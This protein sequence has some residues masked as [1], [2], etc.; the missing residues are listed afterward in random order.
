MPDHLD[1]QAAH[2]APHYRLPVC[3][4]FT[5]QVDFWEIVCYRADVEEGPFKLRHSDML[6][7]LSHPAFARA[8]REATHGRRAP[9]MPIAEE[10]EPCYV[11]RPQAEGWPG[12]TLSK[13]RAYVERGW[14]VHL[15]HHLHAKWVLNYL[16]LERQRR[17]DKAGS[18]SGTSPPS[19]DHFTLSWMKLKGALESAKGKKVEYRKLKDGLLLLERQGILTPLTGQQTASLG[20]ARR[21]QHRLNVHRL[22]DV[23]PA[24]LRPCQP[25]EGDPL[26]LDWAI[27]C[28]LRFLAGD[29]QQQGKARPW[30]LDWLHGEV[31][32]DLEMERQRRVAVRRELT[33]GAV[34]VLAQAGILWHE[35]AGYALS[36]QAAEELV[37]EDSQRMPFAAAGYALSPQAAEESHAL[38]DLKEQAMQDLARA[39]GNLEG[40]PTPSTQ[41]GGLDTLLAPCYQRDAR[42]AALAQAI[43]VQMDYPPEAALSLFVLLRRRMD[44]I[45]ADAFPDLLAHFAGRQARGSAS[46]DPTDILD[47]FV[48]SRQCGH[49][50]GGQRRHGRQGQR[51]TARKTLKGRRTAVEGPLELAADPQRIVRARLCCTLRHGRSLPPDLAGR[52]LVICLAA[53]DRELYRTTVCLLDLADDPLAPADITAPL[54]ALAG[55][56]TLTVRLALPARLPALRLLVRIEALVR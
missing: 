41:A 18:R 55:N 14:I 37:A 5:P 22:L 19:A 20:Y 7:L 33:W 34:G 54:R 36:P 48:R 45:P 12:E 32:V 4:P 39:Q 30:P 21:F 56:A 29:C 9:L 35:R 42:R 49:R 17:I 13:L 31:E 26:T 8:R 25:A 24:F 11:L 6:G 38:A 1:V 16:L 10:G 52:P 50:P 3:H 44:H 47:D 23:A 51:L 40:S 15:G 53:G 46:L 27:D 2:Q 43:A 28:V